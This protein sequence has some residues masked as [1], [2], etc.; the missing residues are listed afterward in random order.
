MNMKLIFI[1]ALFANLTLLSSY[2]VNANEKGEELYMKNCVVCHGYD[3]SGVMP[4]VSDLAEKK[5]WSEMD[6]EIL[7]A[8][9]KKGIKN[10]AGIS[11]PAK[12]GNPGLSDDDI[13]KII[14]FM[15][16]EFIK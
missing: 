9:L 15:R 8:R 1:N 16:H 7:L 4:G 11:M 2:A 13:D 6:K 5:S 10:E 12:G 14:D 3:G